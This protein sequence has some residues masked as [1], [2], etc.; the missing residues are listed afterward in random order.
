MQKNESKIFMKK[1]EK[2]QEVFNEAKLI[3]KACD[4]KI[5]NELA[6]DVID[7]NNMLVRCKLCGEK[8]NLKSIPQEQLHE[9]IKVILDAI[10]C[11]KLKGE[12]G[13]KSYLPFETRKSLATTQMLLEAIPGFYKDYY[14][15]AV[16]MDS[17]DSDYSNGPCEIS[18]DNGIFVGNT[19]NWKKHHK[20]ND[21]GNFLGKDKH[22]NKDK[23][24]HDKKKKDKKKDKFSW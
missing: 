13:N 21:V 4:H 6:L 12:N 19:S 11:I 1:K 3:K 15:D 8:F 18:S 2:K 7:D 9:S 5:E 23:K 20:R 16:Q 22:K 10:N 24:K 14:L 17:Y